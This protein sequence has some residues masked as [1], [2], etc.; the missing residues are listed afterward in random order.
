MSG[1]VSVEGGG[2]TTL[3]IGGAG[4]IGSYLVPKLLDTDRRVTVIGRR[5]SPLYEVPLGASY[6]QGDYVHREFLCG[7]LDKHQEVILLAYSSVPNTSFEDP[8][9]DLLQNLPP[10]VQL[11]EEMAKR[12]MKLV[13][14]SSGGTIYGEAQVLPITEEH[15]TKPI[16]PYGVTKLTLEH[17]AHLYS[18]THGLKYVCVRPSNA[19]GVGQRPFAGQ[20]FISTAMAHAMRGESVRVFGEHGVIRDYLYVSD[21]AAGITS[22]LLFGGLG[23]TYNLGSGKGVSTREVLDAMAPL[24]REIGY[25]LRVE[26]LPWR[27]FDVKANILDASKLTADT[28]WMPVVKFNDGLR[29]MRDWLKGLE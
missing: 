26:H 8:L 29:M 2:V 17:Y 12:K 24:M 20:G 5:S 25:T 15:Q 13:L 4:Y 1:C 28:D 19:Y 11:F 18:I 7:L 21:L 6:I 9:S 10:A 3:V 27:P 22:A 16:S 23:A 14:V